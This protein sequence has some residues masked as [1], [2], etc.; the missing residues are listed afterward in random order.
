MKRIVSIAALALIALAAS[1]QESA[2]GADDWYW[3]KPLVSVQWDGV[4]HADKRE[5][6][7]AVKR[8][9]G[10]EFTSELWMDIQSTIYELDW[11]ESFAPSAVASDVEKTGVIIKFSVKEKPSIGSVRV[12]GNSGVKTGDILDAIAEKA[13]D[14][15]NQSKTKVDELAVR[16]LYLERGYP[17]VSVSSSAQE[18]KDPGT[19][20]L[21]FRI[22]EG[23]QVAIR[24]IRFSGNSSVSGKTLQGRLSL[25]AAGFLQAGTF[26]EA[27]LEE[28]KRTIIDYYRSRGYVDA[29][30]VDVLRSY[31]KDEKTSKTWLIIDIVVEEGR[32]WT[33][34]G[35]GFEG[36]VIFPTEKLRSMVTLKAGAPLNYIKLDS[37]KSKIDDLYMES[38]YIFNT[39]DLVES[40]DEDKQ[41]ISY[42]VKIVERD[43]AHIESIVIKGNE[44]TKDYVIY[45]EIPLEVGDIFS[46]SRI[47]DGLRNLYGLQ[48]FSFINPELFAG[49]ANGLTSLV[50]TVE[51]QSTADIQ[52]GVT[53][54]G[55]G[56][57]DTFPISGMIKW[58]DRNF[59]GNGTDFS[60]DLS[61]SPSTQSLSFGYTDR[62]FFGEK[63]SGGINLSF[64]HK[65][66]SAGQ[67]SIFP[68]FDDGVPDPFTEAKEGGY[69]ISQ[70][71]SAYLMPYHAF[72]LSLGF[73]SGYTMRVPIGDLGF[74]GAV[75]F[76]LGMKSFEEGFRPAS[77]DLRDNVGEWVPENRLVARAYLNDLDLWYSPSSGYY[78]SQKLTWAGLLPSESQHYIR[79]DTKAEG[80]VKL[81]EVPVFEDW[82]WKMVLGAHT[83][84][85][86][87]V[88]KPWGELQ[89]TDDW[90]YL[91]GTFNARGWKGLYGFEGDA[92]WENWLELRMP[93]FEQFLW[94]DGFLDV[95]AMRT[96][97]GMVNMNTLDIDAGR[98]GFSDMGWEDIAFSAGFGLR[99]SIMQ[100][101][102]KFYFAKRFV[103]DGT[104]LINKSGSGMD[105]VISIT[106]T[107][108]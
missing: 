94:V 6:D 50:F 79:T 38:G 8:Y 72:N 96:A 47:N 36:N 9:I 33:F 58:S 80:Y 10:K 54:S 91:D 108:N 3:G 39:I 99:F 68:I 70:I 56:Q 77:K 97:G 46:K 14:I 27:K 65:V 40:R 55:L 87:L 11:F 85:S 26:Q 74:G 41:S 34:G 32:L 103:F 89:V 1:A 95:A 31:E 22:S 60:V 7:S 67:D 16:R 29:R 53:L 81:F 15:Y 82:S 78:L 59:L 106:Q 37:E 66:L 24:E 48:Y 57:A 2:A 20:I 17:D 76:G 107:L 19:I 44:R 45:R 25:K 30:I 62:Y 4:V 100:F 71:P 98:S 5:L 101:P 42:T 18:G 104:E 92:I 21:S 23:S 69:S 61:A 102:F 64:S 49:S 105:I 52:F 13:G 63:I 73:S 35:I 86:A 51:E 93:I 88:A 84:F 28:D 83:G 12:A 75:S 90:L 43:R